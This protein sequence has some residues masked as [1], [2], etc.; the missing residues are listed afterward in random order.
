MTEQ[1]KQQSGGGAIIVRPGSPEV[2]SGT[3]T[4]PGGPVVPAINPPAGM[5]PN[6]IV[7]TYRSHDGKSMH[8]Y[9]PGT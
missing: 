1:T 6:L 2:Q 7:R 3:I 4:P 5:K 8:Q 9:L